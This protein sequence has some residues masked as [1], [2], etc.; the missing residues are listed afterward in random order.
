MSPLSRRAPA[1]IFP[2]G[3]PSCAAWST[4]RSTVSKRNKCSSSGVI[5]LVG[6]RTSKASVKLS[7]RALGS[8]LQSVILCTSAKETHSR[9]KLTAPAASHLPDVVPLV[10]GASSAAQPIAFVCSPC[11]TWVP[12][13]PLSGFAPKIW[14]SSHPPPVKWPPVTVLE[15]APVTPERLQ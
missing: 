10:L 4:A 1:S 7:P 9:R 8:A 15:R 3:M 6:P 2:G 11:M 12:N 5:A 14:M 13:C